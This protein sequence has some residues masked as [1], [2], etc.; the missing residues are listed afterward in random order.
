[1]SPRIA[2][3]G[4]QM[5]AKADRLS[6][7]ELARVAHE[8][9]R[10][11]AELRCDPELHPDILGD[12]RK[13]ADQIL[14]PLVDEIANVDEA[15][16]AWRRPWAV[17]A[18]VLLVAA[19]L[20][21]RAVSGTAVLPSWPSAAVITFAVA[22]VAMGC[23]AFVSWWNVTRRRNRTADVELRAA[24]L[25]PLRALLRLIISEL[26]DDEAR[27][28]G[29]LSTTKAPAL[30]E[31][32]LQDTIPSRTYE[33]LRTFIAEHESSA[34]GV[35]G[36]RGSGKT[37]LMRRLSLDDTLGCHVALVST[38]VKY[39]AVEFTRLI[40]GELARAGLRSSAA[41]LAR[42]HLAAPALR[43]ALRTL[44]MAAAAL[45]LVTLW[46]YD[47]NRPVPTS[48]DLGWTGLSAVALGALILG[49]ALNRA[50]AF[51]RIRAG[52]STFP[53]STREL[54]LQQLEFLRWSTSV[55]RSASAAIK[56]SGSGFEGGSKL[57][58]AE[59][60]VTHADAVQALRQF[61][62]QLLALG[63]RPVV[64]CVD[65]LD[66]LAD[67]AEAVDAI[68]GL[69]D[70]FHVAKAH[71]V[72]SVST[73]AMLSFAARGVPMRDVFDSAFDTIISVAPLSLDE[74][75]TLISRRARDFSRVFVLFCHAWS[76]GHARDLIR[77]ARSCVDLK[78]DLQDGEQ[79]DIALLSRRVLRHD[80][81]EVVD[82]T[83]EKL[84][85]DDG[86]LA[87]TMLDPVLAFQEALE[88]DAANLHD[89]LKR[90]KFPPDAGMA[91]MAAEA[92]P[93]TTLAP[94]ARIA[95]LCERLFSISRPPAAWQAEAMSDAVI[96]L[97]EARAALG[98]HPR[99]IE[100]KLRRAADACALADVSG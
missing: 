17:A 21:L 23:F 48:F 57:S 12:V 64:I 22:L 58:Q 6:P 80:L 91:A 44:L 33:R 32:N 90:I 65:E 87:K 52:M 19:L 14:A 7:E 74:S 9:L 73:D 83:V 46:L 27:W 30:V 43:V 29:T 4:V 68:N 63:G 59:R 5:G 10:H 3:V 81:R 69:K 89:L 82:A 11:D 36:A 97:A 79:A 18:L 84:R 38:P 53:Q 15:R 99:E 31:L 62:E 67:P 72:L 61:V 70:L 35:A 71:F 86:D 60:E 37:T 51:F 85:G 96:A 92:R 16:R 50:W 66:K 49:F 20:V 76:G 100:R 45:L 78:R 24:L 25:P 40:H 75:Q 1:M 8:L 39:A 28:S 54:C 93:A 88:D 42:R 56:V 95:A 34:T 98:R 2:V 94:Y 47:K 55:E 41:G 13:R 77:T 26:Q